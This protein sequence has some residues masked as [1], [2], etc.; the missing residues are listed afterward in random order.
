M[1]RLKAIRS[2]LARLKMTHSQSI[3]HLIKQAMRSHDGDAARW[4]RE[5]QALQNLPDSHLH[6]KAL[7]Q[8]L[9]YLQELL[10]RGEP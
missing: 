10:N 3:P 6:A 8:A 7:E 4:L 9:R 2:S 5:I 1:G